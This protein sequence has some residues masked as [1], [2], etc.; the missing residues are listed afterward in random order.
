[1]SPEQLSAESSGIATTFGEDMDQ[2]KG[3]VWV[4]GL[5]F[6]VEGEQEGRRFGASHLILRNST[7]YRPDEIRTHWRTMHSMQGPQDQLPRVI[8]R[9]GQE[10]V[11]GVVEAEAVPVVG[12]PMAA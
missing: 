4:S 12:H 2:A 6:Y 3:R 9:G 1:M 10:A 8:G 5:S 7:T 11:V